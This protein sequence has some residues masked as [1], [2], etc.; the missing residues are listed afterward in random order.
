[1]SFYVSKN[2]QAQTDIEGG[3]KLIE[4]TRLFR[5]LYKNYRDP[6]PADDSCHVIH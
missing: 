6:G 4:V 5:D 1:M 2:Q 3:K